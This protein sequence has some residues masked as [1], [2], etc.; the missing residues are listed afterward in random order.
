LPIEPGSLAI[1]GG[2]FDPVHNAHLAIARHALEALGAARVLWMPTGAPEYRRAPVASAAHRVA[3]LRLAI[4]GEPRYALDERELAPGA[5][6]YT[7]DTLAALRAEFGAGVPLL[8]LIGADQYAKLDT[9]H[10]A[11]E[12][13]S[14]CRFAVFARPG[15]SVARTAADVIR[16]EMEPPEVSASEIRARVGRGAEF[17]D[18]VPPPVARYIREHGLYR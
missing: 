1:L 16:V 9:W 11:Q 15:W 13:P 3:M 14:L 10:R 4:A 18:L 17:S 12:L 8:M 7:V 6:P 2:T 5:S